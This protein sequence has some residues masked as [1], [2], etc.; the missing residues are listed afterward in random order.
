MKKLVRE[1]IVVGAIFLVLMGMFT[2]SLSLNWIRGNGDTAFLSELTENIAN[3]GIASSHILSSSHELQIAVGIYGMKADDIVGLP[4]NATDYHNE[5]VLK[6]HTYFILYLLAPLNWILPTH[7]LLPFLTAISFLGMLYFLYYFLRKNNVSI[8]GS[9]LLCFVV[10]A[11]PAWNYAI[12]GEL[13]VDRFFLLLGFVYVLSIHIRKP[14]YYLIGFIGVLC[15]ISNDRIGLY[16][17]AFSIGYSVLYFKKTRINFSIFI[18]CFGVFSIA[19]AIFAMKVLLSKVGAGGT[20]DSWL[21]ISVLTN[22]LNYLKNYPN[23]YNNVILFA[24]INILILLVLFPFGWRAIVIA[25]GSMIPNILGN[26]GGAEKTG[27]ATHYHSSYFPFFVWAIAVSFIEMHHLQTRF[28]YYRILLYSFTFFVALLYLFL[29]PFAIQK[30]QFSLSQKNDYALFKTVEAM[31]MGKN[32][33]SYRYYETAKRIREAIP[34]GS[35]V[36]TVYSATTY[37]YQKRRVYYYPLAVD[38]A[39]YVVLTH[40]DLKE[41]PP[42]YNVWVNYDP[43][44]NIKMNEFLNERLL[45]KGYDIYHPE[46]FDFDYVVIKRKK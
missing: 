39:D 22:F 35:I 43:E 27:W 17:G 37:F 46:V 32:H 6:Y 38:D 28:R 20:Y 44:E 16:T 4:L 33:P 15:L 34:E 29:F 1:K 31:L 21:T 10:S 14:N 9:W 13:Y 23:A 12:Y 19:Y 5:Y 7:I 26:I 8:L 41:I 25:L 2:Y 36:S 45:K 3:S 30:K 11:H 18:F 40:G 42:K 24:L